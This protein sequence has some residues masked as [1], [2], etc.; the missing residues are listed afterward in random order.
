MTTMELLQ[1]KLQALLG[2]RYAV[3]CNDAFERQFTTPMQT[4]YGAQLDVNYQAFDQYA[5]TIVAVL[6][7]QPLKLYDL[8]YRLEQDTYTLAFWV[9]IDTIKFDENG[10]LLEAP[11]FSFDSDMAALKAAL[12]G[13]FELKETVGE[14]E[15]KYRAF[16][17]CSEPKLLSSVTEKT[18]AYERAVYQVSGTVSISAEALGLGK[19]ITIEFTIDGTG[20]PINNPSNISI[21]SSSQTNSI[22][23]QSGL[24]A[25]QEVALKAQAVSFVVDDYVAEGD[26]AMELIESKAFTNG[27]VTVAVKLSK[28]DN[29]S[30]TFTAVLSVDYTAAGASSFGSYAVTLVDTGV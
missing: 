24:D 19:D 30:R 5:E 8:P 4:A 23:S 1:D 2:N 6:T 16:M 20:Y 15:V 17:T 14:V 27:A 10:M 21:S 11:K 3:F 26:K 22:L 12:Q 28:G 13:G 7:T 29:L 18:G 25:K 9:P